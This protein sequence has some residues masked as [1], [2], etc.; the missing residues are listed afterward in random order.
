MHAVQ[1]LQ[2]KDFRIQNRRLRRPLRM[3]VEENI[4]EGWPLLEADARSDDAVDLKERN[5]QL[6]S[7]QK[8]R[9]KHM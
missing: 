9:I 4:V 8:I 2:R 5:E 1:V 3:R 7:R 6:C